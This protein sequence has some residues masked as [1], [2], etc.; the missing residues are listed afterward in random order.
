MSKT[1]K[2]NFEDLST[3]GQRYIESSIA[4]YKL[5]FFKKAITV[6]V[7]GSHKLILAFFLLIALL[8]LSIAAGIYIGGLLDSLPLGYL[9]IGLFYIFIMIISAYTLKPILRKIILKRASISYFNDKK[10]KGLDESKS[11]Q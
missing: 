5:D 4:F 3:T 8:F 10:K 6:A 11:L 9:I 1:I 7:D 2:E